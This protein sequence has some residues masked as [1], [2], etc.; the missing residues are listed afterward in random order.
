MNSPINKGAI[1]FG[2]NIL[3][4]IFYD[5]CAKLHWYLERNVIQERNDSALLFMARAGL[6]LRYLYQLYRQ[7]NNLPSICSEEDL[8]ISR[9]SCVKGCLTNDF[10]YVVGIIIEE[11]KNKPII[12]VFQRIIELE[13][14]LDPRWYS[15]PTSK[16]S[17][18]QIYE[19]SNCSSLID[20]YFREQSQLFAQYIRNFSHNRQRIF[21]VD[22]GWTGRTQGML[23]RE[24]PEIAW[25]G[26]YFGKWA[27]GKPHPEY[28]PNIIGLCLDDSV[29]HQGHPKAALFHYHH[30]IEDPL[31]IDFPSVKGYVYEQKT[32]L[33][34]PN[35]GIA[36][37]SVILPND[38]DTHFQGIIEY[39]QTC[40]QSDLDQISQAANLAYKQLNH[41]IRFPSKSDLQMMLVGDRSADFGK[42]VSYPILLQPGKGNLIAKRRRLIRSLWKEGQVAL[43]F[44]PV[45]AC[46]IQRLM[47]CSFII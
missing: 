40:Q 9:L 18:R 21:L 31:E 41:L 17:F 5:F 37:E 24:F 38:T 8:Y 36:E 1:Y 27:Y 2:E 20:T 45:M 23:M 29:H 4:P 33:V 19:E 43:E 46:I 44:P 47:N 28:F 25:T 16:T 34:V 13:L 42:D 3:G 26:L 30:L 32:G 10:D 6:R 7:L 39:F 12:D 22:S 11:Y 14:N 15:T 35:T